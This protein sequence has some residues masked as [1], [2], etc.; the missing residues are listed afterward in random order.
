MSDTTDSKS[1]QITKNAV[2]GIGLGQFGVGHS[3]YL[4]EL[5]LLKWTEKIEIKNIYNGYG[6]TIFINKNNECYSAGRNTYKSCIQ[7]DQR[8]KIETV[9]KIDAWKHM[10]ICKIVCS[11]FNGCN[12]GFIITQ[13][14]SIYEFGANNTFHPVLLEHTNILIKDITHMKCAPKYSIALTNNGTVFR[15]DKMT[16]N[17]GLHAWKLI[18]NLHN[19]ICISTGIHHALC[20]SEQGNAY[21]FGGNEYGQLGIG[22][23]DLD[24]DNNHPT[25]ISFFYENNIFVTDV[26]CGS[27][28]SLVLTRTGNVFAFGTNSNGECGQG[29]VITSENICTPTQ[30]QS[31]KHENIKKLK[32]GDD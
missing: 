23:I 11:P 1:M 8:D 20:C 12:H 2:Y 4:H 15:A 21:S 31:L 30:I 10:N 19:I 5:T 3:K 22:K 28:Y 24:D 27:E 26:R 13:N 18:K 17:N 6:F 16:N 9:L 7:N 29:H 32:C 25:I 14:N